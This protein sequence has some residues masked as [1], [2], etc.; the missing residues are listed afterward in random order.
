MRHSLKDSI[1]GE[2]D[3]NLCYNKAVINVFPN[4]SLSLRDKNIDQALRIYYKLFRVKAPP[5]SKLISIKIK[6]L[7]AF[8]TKHEIYNNK[9]LTGYEVPQIF[10]DLIEY[11]LREITNIYNYPDNST[12]EFDNTEEL[13]KPKKIKK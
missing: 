8:T 4:F 3:I 10:K 2:L 5:G 13:G 9:I 12:I 11:R 1:I 6:T 7:Y